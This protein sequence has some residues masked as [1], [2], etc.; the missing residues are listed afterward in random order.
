MSTI[1]ETYNCNHNNLEPFDILMNFS[2]A[3]IE[4]IVKNKNVIYKLPHELLKDLRLTFY[5]QPRQ[6]IS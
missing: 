1:F 2:S 6:R 4:M 5:S 3:T